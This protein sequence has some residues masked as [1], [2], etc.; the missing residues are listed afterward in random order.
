MGPFHSG[1]RRDSFKR[2][3]LGNFKSGVSIH[4]VQPL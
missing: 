4:A 2:I 1:M 3:K